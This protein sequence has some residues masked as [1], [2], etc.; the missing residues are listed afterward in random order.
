M[1]L[2]LLN[3]YPNVYQGAY[4]IGPGQSEE[5]GFPPVLLDKHP[6]SGIWVS[7]NNPSRQ[8]GE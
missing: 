6:R 8:L 4:T 1:H 7:E 5:I 2:V 3:I